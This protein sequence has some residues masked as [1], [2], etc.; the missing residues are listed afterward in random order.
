MKPEERDRLKL[1]YVEKE[2]KMLLGE[3]GMAQSRIAELNL[4]RENI[5]MS[6]ED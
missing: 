3:I 1:K 5:I 2:R 6:R 4:Q